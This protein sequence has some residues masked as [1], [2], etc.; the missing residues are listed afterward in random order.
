[1][2]LAASPRKAALPPIEID[3]SHKEGGGQIVRN[4]VAYA[5]LLRRSVRIS[6]VRAHRAKNPGVR[7][8]HLAGIKLAAEIGNAIAGN[9][10]RG[11]GD[12][13]GAEVGSKTVSYVCHER[14]GDGNRAAK[15]GDGCTKK[16]VADTGTAGSV[17]LLLQAGFLPG[18]VHA[19]RCSRIEPQ[20]DK[21]QSVDSTELAVQI[22]LRGGTNATAA[23]QIDYIT[24]VFAPFINSYLWSNGLDDDGNLTGPPLDV[25]IIQRGYYPQGGGRVFV[26]LYPTLSSRTYPVI[27][28]TDPE[29]IEGISIK[30]FH[31]GKC[32]RYVADKIARGA[33]KELK[34]TWREDS[35]FRERFCDAQIDANI[36]NNVEI[37][38]VT[39]CLGSGSGILILAH[40]KYGLDGSQTA[41]PKLASSG[42]GDRKV[43]PLETGTKAARE[44]VECITSGG[45]VDRWMQDQII[46]FMALADA[47]VKSE[48]LV[49][50]LTLHTQTAM[51]VAEKMTGCKF[52]VE[53]L[54]G[55]DDRYGGGEGGTDCYGEAGRVLGKHIIRC[56][57]IGYSC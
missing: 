34:R 6:D 43:S 1:M 31:A 33:I 40:P 24:D 14:D 44:L 25:D 7:P 11:R 47:T 57:G 22:D 36:V 42:V 53:R 23:P 54:D 30:V 9:D 50:E 51:W 5:V 52:E 12:L 17:A 45:C 3:G 28:L 37:N 15:E 32:P 39:D 4:A 26:N 8:Q 13:I 18:L 21:S 27:R 10:D 35:A 20:T 2:S 41:H 29:P 19:M 38:H 49:G 48:V 55:Q 16:F 46:P 56:H